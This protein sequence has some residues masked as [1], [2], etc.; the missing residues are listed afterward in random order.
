MI[1]AIVLLSVVAL[2]VYLLVKW[3]KEAPMID[4]D[5]PNNH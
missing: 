1:A 4:D 5:Y 2:G 3:I